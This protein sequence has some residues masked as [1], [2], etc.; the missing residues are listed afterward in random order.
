MRTIAV[1]TAARSDYGIYLPVLRRI[2]RESGLC[3]QLWVTGMHLD[4]KFGYTV[5]T[6]ERDGFDIFQKIEMLV[7]SDEPEDIAVSIGNG[8]IGFAKAFSKNRPDILVVL[9]D[10]F[11]MLAAVSAALP[12]KIPV[13]HIHGGEST[14][15]L[16]DEAIRHALTKMSHLHFVSTEFYEKR[17]M[18]MG[19]EPW[20]ITVSGAPSLDNLREL[21]FLDAASIQEKFRLDV[22]HPFLLVTF[23]PVTLEY[24]QT[25]G[26]MDVLL[27]ALKDSRQR[28]IFTC[29]NAD[30]KGRQ[31]IQKI[32]SFV[33]TNAMAQYVLNLGT[34]GY[35]SW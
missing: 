18:Q 10:R 14:E 5:N 4:R 6:I 34:E 3:L 25:E 2:Q 9:G 21:S 22:S 8:T 27:D 30:T 15:G 19:E 31:L 35:F 13:A 28:V 24:E 29:P 23:H 11:E 12:F 32:E 16:M 33:A 17:I 26:Q 1:V 20:R 7:P